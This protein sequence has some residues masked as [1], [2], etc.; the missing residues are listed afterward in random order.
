LNCPLDENE[1]ED[2]EN[3]IT[4]QVETTTVSVKVGGKEVLE[5]VTKKPIN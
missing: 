3:D 5:T 1:Y 4:D 2:I